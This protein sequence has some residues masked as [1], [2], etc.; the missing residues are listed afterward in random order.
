MD[1]CPTLR[2]SD[3]MLW[4]TTN[5]DPYG[6][7]ARL[8]C[9]DADHC[10]RL[11]PVMGSCFGHHERNIQGEC[12]WVG[13]RIIDDRRIVPRQY[14]KAT[15]PVFGFRCPQIDAWQANRRVGQS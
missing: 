14:I 2:V 4:S 3:C 8:H 7:L 9:P 6:P 10:L 13:A 11:V 15:G 5:G 1:E 12:P